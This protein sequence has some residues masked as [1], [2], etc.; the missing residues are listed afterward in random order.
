MRSRE[1][2]NA[3]LWLVMGVGVGTLAGI[4]LDP[5]IRRAGTRVRYQTGEVLRSA[6]DTLAAWRQRFQN[7]RRTPSPDGG[8]NG[9]AV[10]NFI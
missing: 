1:R 7:S 6:A 2:G 4:L 8:A 3:A 5:Y 9:E 10:A